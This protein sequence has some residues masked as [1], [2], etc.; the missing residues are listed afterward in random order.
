M[1]TAIAAMMATEET[2]MRSMPL[3]RLWSRAKRWATRNGHTVSSG[4]VQNVAP[5]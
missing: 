1:G 4:V 3:E 5:L 2:T